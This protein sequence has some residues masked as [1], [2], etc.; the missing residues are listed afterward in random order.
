M[1]DAV[2]GEPIASAVLAPPVHHRAYVDA[3]GQFQDTSGQ[4]VGLDW[5]LLVVDGELWATLHRVQGIYRRPGGVRVVKFGPRIPWPDGRIA[6][7]RMTPE[8]M[9]A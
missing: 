9:S 2:V 8:E 4:D 1:A 6:A 7:R 3:G 5:L